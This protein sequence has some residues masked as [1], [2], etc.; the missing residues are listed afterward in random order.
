MCVFLHLERECDE[1]N[2]ELG[3]TY[4]TQATQTPMWRC[5]L[6][7]GILGTGAFAAGIAAEGGVLAVSAR[8]AANNNRMIRE[9]V[10]EIVRL[11]QFPLKPSRLRCLY[12]IPP[13]NTGA[14]RRWLGLSGGRCRVLEVRTSVGRYHFADERYLDIYRHDTIGKWWQAA[15]QYWQMNEQDGP[16]AEVLY[17]GEFTVVRLRNELVSGL[18]GPGPIGK[19]HVMA[20]SGEYFKTGDKPGDGVFIC[21]NCIRKGKAKGGEFKPGSFANRGPDRKNTPLPA[22][23]VCDAGQ[24]TEWVC[25]FGKWQVSHDGEPAPE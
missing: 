10:M 17:E 11:E 13:A 25:L 4:S 15:E 20:E 14:L 18:T 1:G 21:L 24:S 3:K 2:F 5:M 6:S 23:P 19:E 8:F 16:T 9:L 22:C 7:R 12:L